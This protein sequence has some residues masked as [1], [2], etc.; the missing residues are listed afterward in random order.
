MLSYGLAA[1]LP[2]SYKP[3]G[4]YWPCT[5]CP[6]A[7]PAV[8]ALMSTE[9]AIDPRCGA[10]N[11]WLLTA[12]YFRWSNTL[13]SVP[14]LNGT[15]RTWKVPLSKLSVAPSSGPYMFDHF[16]WYSARVLES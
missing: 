4:P 6:V 8:S 13:K 16:W 14:A 9:N 2:A 12:M 10:S 3:G 11:V 5:T 7:V 1:V 15:S